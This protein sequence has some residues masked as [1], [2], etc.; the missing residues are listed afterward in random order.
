[1]L[2]H[3]ADHWRLEGAAGV[4]VVRVDSAIRTNS[5][6]VIREAVLAGVGIALRSTWDIGPE[7]RAGRL[8]VVL[9]DYAASR[10]VAVHAVYPS[11]R[12]LAQNVRVF[13]S[14]LSSLYGESPYWD[15]GLILQPPA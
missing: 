3:N 2:V 13:I 15:D 7:I 5:S 9:P 12:H 11:R 6:E 1:L 8:V 14:F 4:E 10:R